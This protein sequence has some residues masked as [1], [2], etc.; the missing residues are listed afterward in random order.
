MTQYN[1]IVLRHNKK[2]L[3]TCFD[4]INTTLVLWL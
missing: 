1:T 2:S 3:E 4:T